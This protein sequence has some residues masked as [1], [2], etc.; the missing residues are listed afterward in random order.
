MRLR[1]LPARRGVDDDEVGTLLGGCLE[2]ARQAG[3]LGGDHHG[4]FGFA[5]IAPVRSGGLGVK[6]DDG[7]CETVGCGG[8]GGGD[9]ERGLARAA[10]LGDD[11]NHLHLQTPCLVAEMVS[12]L[13]FD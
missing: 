10:L 1:G 13:I 9:A 8:N 11:G 3:R 12:L 4:A 6:V 7:G 2:D 5:A